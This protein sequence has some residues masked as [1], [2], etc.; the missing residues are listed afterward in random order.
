[1]AKRK[2][3]A[4]FKRVRMC[5]KKVGAKPFKKLTGEKRRAFNRCMGR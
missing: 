2:A 4:I 1:M 5:M 3:P